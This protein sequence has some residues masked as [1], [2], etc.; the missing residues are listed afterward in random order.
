MGSVSIILIS[1]R[2]DLKTY[3][4]YLKSGGTFQYLLHS[5]EY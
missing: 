5:I 2:L 4:S 3:Y 1:Q